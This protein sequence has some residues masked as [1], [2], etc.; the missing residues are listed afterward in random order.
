MGANVRSMAGDNSMNRTHA[1]SQDDAGPRLMRHVSIG[2]T[3]IEIE[4]MIYRSKLSELK[5]LVIICSIDFPMP[6]SV[7][8]CE[9]MW[10]A[11]YQVIFFRRP[12]FGNS[13]S[14]PSALMTKQEV[15]NRAALAAETAL[16]KLLI[17]Q[18]ELKNITLLG[19]GTA[20]SI[21]FRLGQ[22]SPEIQFSVYA[23]PLFNPAIWDVIRPPWLKRMIRQTLLSRSGLKIAVN[24]LKAVLRRDAL[25]FY[26]QFAQ[27]SAGD[28]DYVSKNEADFAQA[29]L[30][31]Q[32]IAPDIYYYDMQTA[33]IEDTHWNAETT[34]RTR[35]VILSG[36]ETTE[37]WKR[38]IKAEA[39]RLGLPIVFARSG[40][41]FVPYASP[42]V[43]L[44]IL[45]S[46][47]ADATSA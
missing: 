43:L 6:P 24:G 4:T 45:E 33:L 10:S 13:R 31:L 16:F 47:S 40:D 42:D 25:W 29:G 5:P 9:R 12:G 38:K 2:D 20:N 32:K 7:E 36:V 44:G 37:Y 28:L 11:G 27:K 17:D 3:S 35:A 41:L 1:S 19:L 46:Q 39:A 30:F 15:K 18:L 23:N 14:L 8:F 34:K 22:L 21:C 26:R